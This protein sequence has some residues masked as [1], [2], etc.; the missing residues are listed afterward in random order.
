MFFVKNFSQIV[1][2]LKQKKNGKLEN[3]FFE[4]FFVSHLFYKL[5]FKQEIIKKCKNYDIF[6]LLLPE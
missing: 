1:N 6:L 3:K 5:V 2:V 4:Y